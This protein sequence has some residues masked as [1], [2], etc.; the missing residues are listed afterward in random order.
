NQYDYVRF[1]GEADTPASEEERQHREEV[2][3]DYCETEHPV[4]LLH[5]DAGR[6]A[7]LLGHFV[8]RFV[9]L[10][11]TE[12]RTLFNLFQAR[13]TKL[14][15]T[16]RWGGEPGDVALWDNRPTQHYAV[17]DYDDQYRRLSRITLAGD[18]P[19]D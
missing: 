12:S 11:A 6:R 16:V 14:E 5:P 8:K 10:S 15:D 19:V 3:F 7:P 9:G 4:L 1:D 17:A 13:V 2:A 18:I